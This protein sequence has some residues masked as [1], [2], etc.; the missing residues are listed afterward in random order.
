M[1]LKR[2]HA[3][4]FEVDKVYYNFPSDDFI[5]AHDS[6]AY[7][8][9]RQFKPITGI[10]GENKLVVVQKDDRIAVDDVTF[11]ILLTCDESVTYNAINESSIVIR[12]NVGEETVLFLA[13]LGE[14]SGF[15]LRKAH[16]ENM[17]SDV[18]Q[19]AHHGSNGVAR[20]IYEM[21]S[22]KACLWPT[23]EWLWNNDQGN[24][25]NT[26]PWETVE[27]YEFMKN[28]LGVKHH[29]VSKDGIQKLEFP[30]ELD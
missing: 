19:M 3:D 17:K 4:K 26:G 25:F 15:R 20:I 9:L 7:D 29:F 23:P 11:D 1:A 22:P 16:R 27:L 8:T 5:K 2:N 28:E 13:D 24:G 18:V 14:A 6:D 21:V 12:M 30:L 10:L